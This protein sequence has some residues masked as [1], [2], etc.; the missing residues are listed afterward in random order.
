[1]KVEIEVLE[2]DLKDRELIAMAK[3]SCMS[4]LSQTSEYFQ[5]EI[6]GFHEISDNFAWLDTKW[7][8]I[9]RERAMNKLSEALNQSR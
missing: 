5:N 9:Q 4:I 8:L 6:R 7:S 1:M 3:E 2:S